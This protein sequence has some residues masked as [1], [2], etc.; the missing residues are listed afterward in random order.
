VDCIFLHVPLDNDKDCSAQILK[1]A[2]LF[3]SVG[4][5]LRLGGF[6]GGIKVLKQDLAPAFQRSFRHLIKAQGLLVY[7]YKLAEKRS[8]INEAAFDG[9]HKKLRAIWQKGRN[10]SKGVKCTPMLPAKGRMTEQP[11][12]ALPGPSKRLKI[13]HN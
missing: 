7:H 8:S 1:V 12:S 11:P 6:I 5:S 4:G 10:E 9:I 3:P 2:E 13:T